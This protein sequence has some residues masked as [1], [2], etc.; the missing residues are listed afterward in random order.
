MAERNEDQSSKPPGGMPK[1]L[2]TYA[3]MVT[4]LLCFFVFLLSFANTDI[5][6]FKEVLG[7]MKDAFGVR[8]EIGEPGKEGG[9]EITVKLESPLSKSEAEKQR[10]L[11]LL[12]TMVKE[13][14]VEKNTLIIPVRNG[15]KM[16]ITE[17]AGRAMFKPGGTEFTSESQRLLRKLIP[18]MKE[19][20]YKITVEGH[21]DDRPVRSLMYP[22][23]WELS[24][25]R[26]GRVVRFFIQ[27][28][29]LDPRRFS[30]VGHAYT[31]PLVE[32]TTPENRAKNRRV[33]IIFEVF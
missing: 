15:V 6:K 29:Q 31:L 1:W 9:M 26:A 13:E 21:S 33:S 4:L 30:A 32:N 16:E 17:L 5:I 28:G 7:S 20:I 27:Q 22:S 19:T 11:N 10:L 25:A 2:V 12:K 3:D 8:G 23:N 18:T 24:S 14:G